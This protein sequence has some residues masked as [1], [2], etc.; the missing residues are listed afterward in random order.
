MLA[1]QCH[2]EE[3][4]LDEPAW[5]R[6]FAALVDASTKRIMRQIELSGT[7]ITVADYAA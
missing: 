6:L 5:A 7:L 1:A 3:I 4:Y 2:P